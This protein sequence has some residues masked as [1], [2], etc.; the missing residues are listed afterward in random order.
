ML[1]GER[2][3]QPADLPPST[4]TICPV[5]KD[6]ASEARNAIICSISAGLPTRPKGTPETN[7][8]LFSGVP[9]KRST[10]PVSVGPGATALTRTP[11]EAASS[12]AALVKPSTACLLADQTEACAA[13][14]WPEVAE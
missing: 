11:L 3:H 10:I 14:S 8:A 7:A 6:A 13:P 12:A 5:T 9:V 4:E 2:R 1:I